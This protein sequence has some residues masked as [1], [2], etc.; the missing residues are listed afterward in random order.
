MQSIRITLL[1]RVSVRGSQ[2]FRFLVTD[3]RSTADLRDSDDATATP[4]HAKDDSTKRSRPVRPYSS[5]FFISHPSAMT[6]TETDTAS[7]LKSRL[8][9]PIQEHIKGKN[10]K[11]SIIGA[12][13]VGLACAYRYGN[14]CTQSMPSAGLS[15]RS[16]S[17]CRDAA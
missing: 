7:V 14:C 8:L 15:A 6:S 9:T 13:A 12:G 3:T 16:A 5:P 4:L 2:P 17:L 11:V 10:K 1:R